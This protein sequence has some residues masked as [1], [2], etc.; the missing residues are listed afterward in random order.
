MR[1]AMKCSTYNLLFNSK[2]HGWL[3]NHSLSTSFAK[4]DDDTCQEVEEIR[5]MNGGYDDSKNPGLELQ[6]IQI[7]AMISEDKK[8]DACVRYKDRQPEYLKIY[9]QQKH[10][11][12]K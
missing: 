10:N 5:K 3:F 6:L 11:S 7:K 12:G 1:L 8:N 9:Y 4:L 2:K